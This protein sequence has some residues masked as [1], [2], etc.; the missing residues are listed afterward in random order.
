MKKTIVVLA[1]C[2]LYLFQTKSGIELKDKILGVVISKA[3]QPIDEVTE[4]R[5]SMNERND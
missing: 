3:R 4:A 5:D 1:L 2:Y